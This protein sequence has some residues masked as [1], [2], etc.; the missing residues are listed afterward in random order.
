MGR[1][2]V[3]K[4]SLLNMLAGAKVSIVDPT[5]GVTRDRVSAVLELPS[6]RPGEAPKL[7]E[8]IDTG[9]YG[10]YVAE[11]ARF[12]DVGEDLATL[13]P[14]IE[15]QIAAAVATADLTLFVIDA[16]AGVTAADHDFARLLREGSIQRGNVGARQTRTGEVAVVANKVDDSS[17]EAH[18]LEAAGLGFGEPLMVSAESNYLRRTFNERLHDLLPAEPTHDDAHDALQGA[19]PTMR[20][21]I[22]GKRNSGKSTMVNAM[23]GEERVIVSEIAGSTRDAVDVRFERDGKVFV[24]ID[25]AG[26]RKKKSMHDQVEWWALERMRRAVL[27]ADVVLFLLDA[28]TPIS[29]V[30]KTLSSEVQAAFKP[31]VIVVNKWDLAEGQTGHNGKPITTDRYREYID[32]ELKGLSHCPIAFTSAARG[33]E[34]GG[35]WAVLNVAGELFE[36]TAQRV[37]T[38]ELN[39]VFREFVQGLPASKLGRRLKI[40]YATQ[41]ST[42]PPTIVLVVNDPGLYSPQTERFLLNRIREALPFAEVPVR[43]VI[44]GRRKDEDLGPD[45]ERVKR[46]ADHAAAKDG[47]GARR[48]HA[49]MVEGISAEE[50][51]GMDLGLED[52]AG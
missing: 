8:V 49:P 33:A 2:N 18:A 35:A 30:D 19:S 3:G 7:V 10:V 36:Q 46:A 4:S 44:R 38:G 29:T 52:D 28:T 42:A 6:G 15:A 43:L 47:V 51:E 41:V 31:C 24:A 39:R 17:W 1:P 5:P 27:R 45:P 20:V 16:Q 11:G 13:T 48:E 22:I 50:F 12:N 21:A 23:A 14:Q 40:Y 32:K 37:G 34:E 9:G 26:V 25:T